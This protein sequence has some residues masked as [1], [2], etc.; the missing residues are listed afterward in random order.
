MILHYDTQKVIKKL[1]ANKFIRSDKRCFYSLEG[2]LYK[3][4]RHMFILAI[5][6]IG[7]Y[8]TENFFKK[9]NW[10]I[11]FLK[12]TV[13]LI[14]FASSSLPV[15]LHLKKKSGGRKTRR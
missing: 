13:A 11:G 14:E 8:S 15:K 1:Y 2:T 12:S 4:T 10:M 7:G 6:G 9:K 5:Q 3:R